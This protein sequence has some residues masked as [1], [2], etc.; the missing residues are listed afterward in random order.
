MTH[1]TVSLVK[2]WKLFPATSSKRI[3][4]MNISLHLVQNGTKQS[5]SSG[6]V[7]SEMKITEG[8]IYANT[9]QDMF[10]IMYISCHHFSPLN[11]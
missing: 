10:F 8:V 6:Q 3:V 7:T 1:Q 5:N 9:F 4:I 2:Y 11:G